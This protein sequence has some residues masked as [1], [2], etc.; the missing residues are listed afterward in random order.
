MSFGRSF[1]SHSPNIFPGTSFYNY[2]VAPFWSD[3]DIT[4]GVGQV[5]YQV[6]NDSQSEA[7]SFVSTYVKQQQHV[8]FTGTWMAVAEWK[9]V[10]EYLGE[11]TTVR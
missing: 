9:G 11:V 6:Y 3:N 4:N 8:N 5:S 7:L 2:L 1:P 10:P